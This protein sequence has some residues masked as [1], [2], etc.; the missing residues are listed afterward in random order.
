MVHWQMMDN[1]LRNGE[2][3][4]LMVHLKQKIKITTCLPHGKYTTLS[5]NSYNSAT[6]NQM[7]GSTHIGSSGTNWSLF[8]YV[9]E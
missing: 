6:D 8:Q 5:F 3:K 2:N 4:I 1:K 9:L 7:K